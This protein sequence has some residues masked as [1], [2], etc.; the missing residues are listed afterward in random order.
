MRLLGL[1][2]GTRK[3]GLAFGDTELLIASPLDVW[4][5]G[6]EK[7]FI[8]RLKEL[9]QTE[10]IETVV[11]GI[12]KKRSGADTEQGERHRVFVMSLEQILN[13]PVATVDESFTSKESQRLRTETGSDVSEDALAA[14]LILQEYFETL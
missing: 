8:G 11:V 9:I 5:L 6:E 3:I 12:P 4:I 2:Y 10:E 7:E 13:I 14:M 1:D